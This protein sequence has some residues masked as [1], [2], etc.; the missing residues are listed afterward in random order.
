MGGRAPLVLVGL[1]LCAAA[2]PMIAA[3]LPPGPASLLDPAGAAIATASIAVLWALFAWP[4]FARDRGI[5]TVLGEGLL[6][7]FL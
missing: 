1:L 5:G 4:V 7:F 3:V 6:L 2:G